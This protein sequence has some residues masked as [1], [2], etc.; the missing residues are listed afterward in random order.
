MGGQGG[1]IR[2]QPEDA[3]LT[4]HPPRDWPR[5]V[6]I[7]DDLWE[8]TPPEAKRALE[9]LGSA[10]GINPVKGKSFTVYV[11]RRRP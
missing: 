9:V 1:T 3:F 10:R 4:T 6:V 11:V 2:E 8:Q 7:R 5:F